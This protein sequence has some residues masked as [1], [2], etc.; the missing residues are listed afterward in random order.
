MKSRTQTP[1]NA[2]QPTSPS[3]LAFTH[4]SSSSSARIFVVVSRLESFLRMTTASGSRLV[5]EEKASG[6][7]LEVPEEVDGREIPE[8]NC[9]NPPRLVG[10]AGAAVERR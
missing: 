2:M 5:A 6:S 7:G 9:A 8:E 1:A 10:R 3:S 4:S